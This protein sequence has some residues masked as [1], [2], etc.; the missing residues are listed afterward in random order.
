[1]S[2]N[3]ETLL[4]IMTRLRDPESGCPWDIEQ[5]FQSI[6]PYTI[7]EAYEVAQ[8]IEQ[9]DMNALRDELG[10]LL[11]QVVYHAEMAREAG[12]FDFEDVAASISEK[13]IRRHPHVFGNS[14]ISDANHQ[15]LAWETQKAKERSAE[16]EKG[17]TPSS[18]IDGVALALPA[19]MRA[20]KLQKRA[21]RLGFDWQNTG[22]VLEKIAE[23]LVEVEDA[24]SDSGSSNGGININLSLE[25]GDLLFACVNLVRHKG[26]DAENALRQA[27]TKFEKRFR[28][29]ET[30]I[31]GEN[32]KLEQMSLEEL[33]LIW[34]RVKSEEC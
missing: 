6:A 12:D 33:E 13:M 14:K 29:L 3:I 24:S 10:D 25:C 32:L 30:L 27:N 2:E 11:L 18:A 5:D 34:K 19:L 28:R 26:I 1:M 22:P 4:E 31:A 23:E 21:S 20:Q 8:A 17:N 9:S 7:E 15:S 16:T